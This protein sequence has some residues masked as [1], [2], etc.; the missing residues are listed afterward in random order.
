MTLLNE[1]ATWQQHQGLLPP[2]TKFDIFRDAASAQQADNDSPAL[3]RYSTIKV[4]NIFIYNKLF[5]IITVIMACSVH[6]S[7]QVD[8]FYVVIVLV[9]RIK[10]ICRMRDIF[11]QWTIFG[12]RI[13][14]RF[15]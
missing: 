14:G 4:I 12:H 3:H 10:N 11:A 1:C 5:L 9:S 7:Y 6:L 2:D 13:R 8:Y 15:H